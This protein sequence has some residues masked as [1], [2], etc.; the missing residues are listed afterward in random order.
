MNLKCINNEVQYMQSS[1]SV[2]GS[3]N[4]CKSDSENFV[5]TSKGGSTA[6]STEKSNICG[7]KPC[8]GYQINI[9]LLRTWSQKRIK[10]EG[11]R[12]NKKK[13][14]FVHKIRLPAA[15]GAFRLMFVLIK[16]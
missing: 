12:K 9:Y 1:A 2:G 13:S 8:D 5:F 10:E 15:S 16:T 4:R 3:E 7:G 11:Y 6:D 14:W